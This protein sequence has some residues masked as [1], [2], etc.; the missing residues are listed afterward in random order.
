MKMRV[1]RPQT[2]A[3][4]LQ[5]FNQE[6]LRTVKVGPKFW[7]L[8]AE[9]EANHEDRVEA[10]KYVLRAQKVCPLTLMDYPD[11]SVFGGGVR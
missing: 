11:Q 4:A 5:A 7:W 9:A 2:C 3:E 6:P 10:I 1:A 8:R